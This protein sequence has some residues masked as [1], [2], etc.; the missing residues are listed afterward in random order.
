MKDESN[1]NEVEQNLYFCQYS[2]G[3]HNRIQLNT[4]NNYLATDTDSN[5]FKFYII[6][7]G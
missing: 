3:Q 4:L 5:G 1:F 7:N 2:N 6:K